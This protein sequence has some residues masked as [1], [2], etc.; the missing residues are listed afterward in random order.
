MR[1]LFPILA[2]IAGSFL[3]VDLFARVA[4]SIRDLS[5]ISVVAALVVH[6]SAFAYLRTSSRQVVRVSKARRLPEWV[7]AQAE[8]NR[9]KAWMGEVGG[10]P[11][12]VIAVWSSGRGLGSLV[13]F[14][15]AVAFQVGLFVAESVIINAQSRLVEDVEGW[16]KKP[17][18]RFIEAA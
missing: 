9:R 5:W 14:A 6:T 17:E 16:D 18:G 4:W 3:L 7:A 1:R 2:L 11:L 15:A 12:V 10:L 8:K 13:L